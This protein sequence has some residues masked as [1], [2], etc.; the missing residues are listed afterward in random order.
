MG[1]WIKVRFPRARQCRQRAGL[2]E[3]RLRECRLAQVDQRPPHVEI[4]I[5][6]PA[7][8]RQRPAQR[9]KRLLVLTPIEASS[10][11]ISF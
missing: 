7:A 1:L 3:R 4:C 2:G 9:R 10:R 6:V 8:Q 11:P 5:S